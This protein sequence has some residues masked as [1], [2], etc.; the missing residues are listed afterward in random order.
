MNT[1]EHRFRADFRS[2]ERRMFNLII[3]GVSENGVCSQSFA[4]VFIGGLR[5]LSD[6]D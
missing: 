1:D 2:L 4:S 6:S 5:I 3:D